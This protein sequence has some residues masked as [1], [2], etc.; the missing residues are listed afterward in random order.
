M[1]VI[2]VSKSLMQLGLLLGQ[3]SHADTCLLDSEEKNGVP[4]TT[5]KL[6]SRTERSRL[7][8]LGFFSTRIANFFM[9]YKQRKSEKPQNLCFGV[10]LLPILHDIRDIR[11]G[12]NVHSAKCVDQEVG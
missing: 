5:C 6:A 12:L 7:T 11:R 8:S 2:Y 9:S 3:S 1:F 10:L 4:T